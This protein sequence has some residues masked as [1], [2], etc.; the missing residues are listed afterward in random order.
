VIYLDGVSKS[1]RTE[2]G[3]R[4]ILDDV[5]TTLPT[6]KH[7][8]V[9]GRNGT[10]KSTFLRMISGEERP[11][12]GR[13]RRNAR[14]SWPLG[15]TGGFHPALTGREN[16]RFISRVYDCDVEEV[17]AYV[18]NFSELGEYFD[19]PIRTLSSGMRA[20]L[21]FG[22]SLAMRF[23]FYL[24]DELVSVGDHWFRAKAQQEFERIRSEAGLLLVSHSPTTIRKF[25]DTGLVLRNGKLIMFDDLEDAINFYLDEE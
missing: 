1:Y 4:V 2:N 17:T 20:R 16:L 12:A 22:L 5:T 18:Q 6:N 25:C 9:L 24:I 19:M 3:Y 13:I 7:I 21:A 23:E 10:G 11:D 8:G 14:V 15:F